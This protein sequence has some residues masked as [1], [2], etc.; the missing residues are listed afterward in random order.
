[1]IDERSLHPADETLLHQAPWPFLYAATSDHRF[2]DRYWFAGVDP[3][4][5]FGFVAGLAV[6][7]NMGVCDGFLCILEGDRQHNSRFSRALSD[8]VLTTGVGGLS[9]DVVE[10]YRQ[11]NVRLDNPDTPIA[12]DLTFTSDHAP[13]CEAHYVDSRGGRVGQEI[14]RYHQPGRWE[15]WIQYPENKATV[16]DWWGTRDHSWGVRPGVGGFDRSVADPQAAKAASPTAPAA[17]LLHIALVVEHDDLWVSLQ[18]REDG[19]GRITFSDIVAMTREGLRLP[20]SVSA[21]DITFHPGTRQYDEVRLGLVI[22]DGQEL[23]VRATP[24]I[25]AWAYAGTGYDGGYRDG[26]GLGAWRG[27]VAEYDVYVHADREE[28]LLDGLPTPTG[29]REQLAKMTVNGIDSTGYCAVM[30]RGALPHRGLAE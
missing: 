12:A 8:D 24:L 7:K 27:N 25:H 9:V 21:F 26:R 22:G 3:S 28:V 29:H 23:T 5:G 13:A 14:T 10:P 19:E 2:F 18:Q 1:M 16:N 17:S 11:I 6:Y 15:G 4:G 20:V 30:T